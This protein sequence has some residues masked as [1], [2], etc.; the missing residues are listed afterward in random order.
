VT[1][2]QP[3]TNVWQAARYL[4][5]GFVAHESCKQG[6]VQLPVPDFGVGPK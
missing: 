1:G 4:V 5:P 2:E 6:G 3:P